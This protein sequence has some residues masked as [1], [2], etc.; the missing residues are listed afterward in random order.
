MAA[1][2]A[3]NGGGEVACTN[4]ARNSIFQGDL[5]DEL[6]RLATAIICNVALSALM[7]FPRI[8]RVV[9]PPHRSDIFD[10]TTDHAL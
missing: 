5:Q 3:D 7:D 9:L 10:R 8:S 1:R 6:R 4:I 2:R